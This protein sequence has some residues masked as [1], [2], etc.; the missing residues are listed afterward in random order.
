LDDEIDEPFS[1][2]LTAEKRQTKY[3]KSGW[4][5]KGKIKR[6]T[7]Y[8]ISAIHTLELGTSSATYTVPMHA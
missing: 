1:S 6:T 5:E 4:E 3:R 8:R 2:K 7:L